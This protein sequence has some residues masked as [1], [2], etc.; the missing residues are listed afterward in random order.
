MKLFV[1]GELIDAPEWIPTR[2][3]AEGK[4][5][6]CGYDGHHQTSE[7]ED[8]EMRGQCP[9]CYAT[10]WVVMEENKEET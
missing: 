4:C 3:L 7:N 5:P 1:P 6:R 8:G 10:F 2:I 9:E